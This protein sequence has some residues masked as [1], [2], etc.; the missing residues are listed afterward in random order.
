[1]VEAAIQAMNTAG[2]S[3]DGTLTNIVLR[4]VNSSGSQWAHSQYRSQSHQFQMQ[5]TTKVTINS[6]GLCFNTDTAADNA[7]S[8]YEQGSFTPQMHDGNGS[9]T[10]ITVNADSCVY[11]KIGTLVY[12]SG[13]VT[14]N[15]SG[16]SGEMVLT[17]LPFN[18]VSTGQ[19]AAGK[20]VDG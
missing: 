4:S 15:D 3:G 5:G 9:N 14:L 2:G 8:D 16:K 18:S 20:L 19:L 10:N 13:N 1:M 12:I 17:H 11:V 7:L 6:N